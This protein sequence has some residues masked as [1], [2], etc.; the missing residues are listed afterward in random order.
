[1]GGR[2]ATSGAWKS[3][4]RRMSE[5]GKMPTW[6]MATK[7]Q[8]SKVFKEI[9]KLYSMPS[10]D[11]VKITDQGDGIWIDFGTKVKRASYPSGTK[12]S[13]AEKNGVK[14]WLLANRDTK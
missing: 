10:T 14:K 8:Q 3:Q 9:D 11:N 6:I 12:A 1:M 13:V 7:E 4:L 5:R 2:G